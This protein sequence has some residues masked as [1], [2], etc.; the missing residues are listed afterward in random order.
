M[1]LPQNQDRLASIAA[2][3]ATLRREGE[4]SAVE[5]TQLSV[6]AA[7][8]RESDLD[9]IN[10][11]V[12]TALNED[13]NFY[14]RSDSLQSGLPPALKSYENAVLELLNL[15]AA[16]STGS[17]PLDA[18]AM[19]SATAK[20]RAASFLLWST[21]AH[22]LDGLLDKRIQ[23]YRNSRS[24]SLGLTALALGFACTAVYLIIRQL[25]RT[26]GHLT[27][28]LGKGANQVAATARQVAA[29]SQTLAAGSSQQAASLEETLQS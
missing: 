14:G 12:Q 1:A 21:V 28:T 24:M 29:S 3:I 16:T 8:V 19:L 7:L 10:A 23:H 2:Y 26:L 17:S 13:A 5:R 9:R 25:R 22:E 4:L 18:D 20:A 6:F 11:D 15:L 27:D